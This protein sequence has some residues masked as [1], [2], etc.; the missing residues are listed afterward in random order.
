MKK[1]IYIYPNNPFQNHSKRLQYLNLKNNREK[2]LDKTD[3]HFMLHFTGYS[4]YPFLK[5]G[6]RIVAKPVPSN[7]FQIGDVAVMRTSTNRLL[8]HRIVRILPHDTG[9]LKGDSLLKSDSKP[10]ALST[11]CGR[12]DAVIRKNRFIS[13]ST[14][15][16]AQFKRVYAWLSLKGLTAGAL[17]LRVKYL[18]MKRRYSNTFE[19]PGKEMKFI[20]ATLG[21]V[22]PQPFSNLDNNRLI[23]TAF[24][25]GV[26]GILY[27]YLKKK[28]IPSPLLTHLR[29]YYEN[30]AAVN[31]IHMAALV[32]LE[33]A[34]KAEEI[35]VMVLKG[36]SLLDTVYSGIGMR[37]MDDL[38]LMVR[39][40]DRKRIANILT[41]LGY[42]RDSR[43]MHV[44]KMERITI[45]VHSHA[46]NIDR[47]ANR[48]S[49]F[50]RGMKPI[51]ESAVPWRKD[52]RWIKR[53]NDVDNVFLLSQHLMKHSFSRLVWLV[54]ILQIVKA[55]DDAFWKRLHERMV[56]LKQRR[57]FLHI[58]Y[59]LH[60]YF[61]F[62]PPEGSGFNDSSK[63]LS[64]IEKGI[65]ELRIQGRPMNR[66][67]PLLALFSIP[68][69]RGQITFFWETVFP[70]KEVLNQE[71]I[72]T[73]NRERLLFYP[74][75]VFHTAAILIRQ[76]SFFI[77]ALV[78][79][80]R[81]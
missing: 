8:V 52:V 55:Q 69:L 44:Y 73:V 32:Q 71:F 79:L 2:R 59:L 64:G 75:R 16:K 9:I 12:V 74:S 33:E 80:K 53:P 17:K 66:L 62:K 78:Q 63:A 61:D 72:N 5:P 21:N 1:A 47:I 14:G 58:L 65:L 76:T 10:A 24:R 49:L 6:D 57:P 18:F 36:V 38:D 3:S 67:G 56:Y 60:R 31:L 39:P 81:Q 54:D 50:P 11:L 13:I 77:A 51:W 15:P 22:S 42:K 37:P 19:I 46:L 20:G 7:A 28:D 45:D 26:G 70:N 29:T 41:G 25:E 40:R 35:E 68:T 4:M 30:T 34:L 43:L 23:R 27:Y 48:A